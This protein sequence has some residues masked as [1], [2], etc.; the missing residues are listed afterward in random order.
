MIKLLVITII[1]LALAFIGIGIKMLLK[2][3]GQFEKHCSSVDPKTG[4][5]LACSCGTGEAGDACRN[6]QQDPEK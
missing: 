6:K 3:G 4:N 5:H 1:L 2:K